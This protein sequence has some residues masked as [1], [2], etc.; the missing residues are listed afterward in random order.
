MKPNLIGDYNQFFDKP[1]TDRNS[2]FG[3][4]RFVKLEVMET[5]NYAMNDEIY[6]K[7]TMNLDHVLPI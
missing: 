3:A 6:L 2:C 5:A 7:V 4:P 1:I